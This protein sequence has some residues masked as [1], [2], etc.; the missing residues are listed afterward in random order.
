METC[1]GEGGPELGRTSYVNGPF[2]EPAVADPLAEVEVP[3]FLA[4]SETTVE[5]GFKVV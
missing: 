2:R 1:R 5:F 4:A 3:H